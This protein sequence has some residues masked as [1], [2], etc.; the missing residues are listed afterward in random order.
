[1]K[2]NDRKVFDV[3]L[4][5][6][7]PYN[8]VPLSCRLRKFLK[9]ALRRYGLRC[10]SIV[11]AKAVTTCAGSTGSATVALSTRT[12]ETHADDADDLRDGQGANVR[13]RATGAG[14]T[15]EKAVGSFPDS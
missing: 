7:R 3:T 9:D 11:E 12:T 15:W 10:T 4:T 1:M 2:N 13:Q 6:D 5:D 8:D 14:S